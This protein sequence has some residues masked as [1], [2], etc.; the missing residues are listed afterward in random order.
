MKKI[1][2][3]VGI[4]SQD[5][6]RYTE[7]LIQSS[8]S[9]DKNLNRILD[10]VF[11]NMGKQVRPHLVFLSARI[12]GNV[13]KKTDYSAVLVQ[14]LHT[15]TLMHD[16]VVDKAEIRRGKATINK[17]W[18]NSVA[19]LTGDY[20][21]A[22]ALSIA[23]REK[24]YDILEILTPTISHLSIG[25]IN[26]MEMAG[27][28]RF[29]TE[30][31]YDI[32]RRKT[33]VL[34]GACTEVG[35]VS[36]GIEGEKRNLIRDI[37]LEAGMIFQMQDDILDFTAGSIFGKATGKDLE[38]KKY[39]LPLIHALNVAPKQTAEDIIERIDKGVK[40]KD[41]K[42]ITKFIEVYD[43]IQYA[44]NCMQQRLNKIDTL[45]KTLPQ[46]TASESLSELI[47]YFAYRKK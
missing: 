40:T 25:E 10:Y 7:L 41:K 27:S 36:I 28:H 4:T 34:I 6:E 22:N 11:S 8:Y 20:L 31:Y 17:T 13:T 19:V 37:G 45:I 43:G 9:D 32:I 30:R 2:E 26:Q 14:S 33:A 3:I 16:D 12:F 5:V 21:F 47:H 44:Q 46:N 39:T 38:E 29:S 24:M 18:K 23:T 42:E 1:D 35:A 15:A